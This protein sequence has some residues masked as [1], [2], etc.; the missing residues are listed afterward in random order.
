MGDG[1]KGQRRGAEERE[2]TAKGKA[3]GGRTCRMVK[4]GRKAR[5]N[6]QNP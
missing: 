1:R 4:H 3:H 2:Q 6:L 5:D